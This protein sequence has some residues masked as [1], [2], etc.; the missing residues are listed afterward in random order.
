MEYQPREILLDDLIHTLQPLIEK[1]DLEEIGIFEEE[2]QGN[3][4]YLGYRVLKDGKEFIVHLPYEKNK[5]GN[6]GKLKQE[7][8][9][10]TEEADDIDLH[11]YKN[12]DEVFYTISQGL[13]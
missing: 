6:L 3:N 4:Y 5:E 10:E 7:W 12:L 2:G 11:G 9:I 13:H 1:Y 8:A